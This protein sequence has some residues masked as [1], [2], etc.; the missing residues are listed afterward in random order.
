[1]IFRLNLTED[2]LDFTLLVD[3]EGHSVNPHI[4]SAHKLLLAIGAIGFDNRMIRIRQQA[5][6][7]IVLMRKLFVP[8]FAVKRNSQ[9]FD[10]TFFELCE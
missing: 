3:Q 9:D 1:M 5:K 7:Q 8:G 10:A 4:R 2:L 6:R